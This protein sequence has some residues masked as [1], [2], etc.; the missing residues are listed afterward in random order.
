MK[1]KKQGKGTEMPSEKPAELI[2]MEHIT[3]IYR[4]GGTEFTALQDLSLCVNRGE[5]LAVMGA[6]GAG[7]TTL[8]NLIGL[9]DG[10]D[11]GVYYLDGV[12]IEKAD[13][14]RDAKLRN[15]V[16][17]YVFQEYSLLPNETVLFNVELPMFFRKT[18]AKQRRTRAEAVLHMA[19]LPEEQ[20]KKKVKFLSGGQKQRVAIARALVND[21]SLILADEPTGSLDSASA[22]QIMALLGSLRER[23]FTV[24]VVTHDPKVAAYCD[25]EIVIS[26][27]RIVPEEL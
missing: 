16:I 24:I 22:A 27:G 7:K 13:D 9:I 17:G 10:F 8:L 25:R 21:P 2:R 12:R 14:S 6:S 3:K 5:M 1:E 4:T 15:R 26:D 18:T 11:S 20:Y 19:G 23:G